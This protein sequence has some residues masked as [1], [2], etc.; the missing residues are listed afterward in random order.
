MKGLGGRGR[1]ARAGRG[2]VKGGK[3]REGIMVGNGGNGMGGG[4]GG[5]EARKVKGGQREKWYGLGK[6][7]RIGDGED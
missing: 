2:K 5:L 3:N 6:T 7:S 1:K 4:K